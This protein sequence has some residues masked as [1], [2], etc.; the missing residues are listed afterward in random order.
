LRHGVDSI[1]DSVIVNCL[2][3]TLSGIVSVNQIRRN[4]VREIQVIVTPLS[5][6]G[7]TSVTRECIH[8]R[9]WYN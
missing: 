1:P 7:Y 4:R 3:M 2:R 6:V 8:S 5:T 9:Q